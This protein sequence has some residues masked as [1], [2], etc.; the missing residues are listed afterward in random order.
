MKCRIL[1]VKNK[2]NTFNLNTSQSTEYQPFKPLFLIKFSEK[3][4]EMYVHLGA[5]IYKL[6]VMKE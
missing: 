5:H 3:T 1:S 4:Y 6:Q 2:L